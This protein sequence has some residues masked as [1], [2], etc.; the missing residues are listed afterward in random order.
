MDILTPSLCLGVV[1]TLTT[2]LLTLGDLNYTFFFKQ[3]NIGQ[4]PDIYG[5]DII[6]VLPTVI[7]N[8]VITGPVV[9]STFY[10]R[11]R[12]FGDEPLITNP[13][14]WLLSVYSV[15]QVVFWAMHFM[16]HGSRTLYLAI[17]QQ[18]HEYTKPFALTAIYCSVYEMLLLNLPAVYFAQLI[19]L[20]ATDCLFFAHCFWL[21]LVGIQTPFAHSGLTLFGSQYHDL[22]H[23]LFTYNFG[24]PIL[25]KIFGVY[26]EEKIVNKRLI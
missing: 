1:F 4:R 25:D 17:H 7:R 21:T 13:I 19:F 26:K 9:L 22:H 3:W 20:P 10:I 15:S 14:L 16:V 18:H 11:V 12:L 2:A 8:L 6:H 5:E 24:S 23:S